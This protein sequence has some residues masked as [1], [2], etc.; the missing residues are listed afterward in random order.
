MRTKTLCL[1]L[2]LLCSL[3]AYTQQA[4]VDW[5]PVGAR[6]EYRQ[7]SQ[8]GPPPN[9][10]VEVIDTITIQDKTC[11]ILFSNDCLFPHGDTL[12]TLCPD[13]DKVY[14]YVQDAFRLLYD[15]SAEAGDTL[16]L[17]IPWG[18]GYDDTTRLE[19]VDSV[20]NIQLG[21]K[22][23]KSYWA[24]GLISDFWFIGDFPIVEKLGSIYFLLP[25]N[26]LIEREAFGLLVYRD[27]CL[28]IDLDCKR[29]GGI[30]CSYTV[31]EFCDTMVN[32]SNVID[33]PLFRLYPVPADESVVLENS[34]HAVVPYSIY[35]L[36]GQLLM[37]GYLP[38]LN[39]LAVPTADLPNGI[40]FLTGYLSEKI[41]HYK[42][43]IHH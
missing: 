31:E 38:A 5:F 33:E 19:V 17:W 1:F 12:A 10:T 41:I 43:I 26:Q 42:F 6:W 20:R 13:G 32:S 25:Q 30:R 14:W 4:T 39:R 9:C 3:I 2:S 34:F 22:T 27:S 24:Q 23:Y 11:S 16:K 36:K 7:T 18:G 29:L 37:E 21:S 8:F 28:K 40:Y 35:N 15:F